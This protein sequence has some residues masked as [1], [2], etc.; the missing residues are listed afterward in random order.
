VSV[1][2]TPPIAL[3]IKF[4]NLPPKLD[5]TVGDP[6]WQAATP[7]LV[8]SGSQDVMGATKWTGTNDFS[9]DA[10]FA[11]DTNYLY[12]LYDVTDD[13]PFVTDPNPGMQWNGDG[14]ELYFGFDQS[15]PS[16]GEGHW[17]WEGH[18]YLDATDYQITIMA[19]QAPNW[20]VKQ[21]GADIP[22]GPQDPATNL[23]ITAR[24]GGYV[25][26]GR[27]PWALLLNND[28][29]SPDFGKPHTAPVLG[30]RAGFNMFGNDGDD[31]AAP[32]QETAMSFNG[33]V[34]ANSWG[35]PAHWTTVL[36][37][38]ADEIVKPK[39]TIA[40]QVDGKIR[41]SWPT[42]AAGFTLQQTTVLPGTWV[43]VNA[44]VQESGAEKFVVIQ[45]P[46]NTVYYH[47]SQ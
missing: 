9:L 32:K 12:F 40:R 8:D 29:T 13:V 11:W 47:L 23:V 44:Q 18:Y 26:E 1:A 46:G 6:A 17:P 2:K 7:F 21:V 24:S 35:I 20:A 5:G 10:R 38:G 14:I 25:M 34:G 3:H 45:P 31:P 41:L 16:R 39:L 42:T 37:V 28:S 36:M 15:N 27:L 33:T 22:V 19:S 4:T 30:Q 43:G